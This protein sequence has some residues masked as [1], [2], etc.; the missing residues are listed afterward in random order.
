[1]K[2]Y[3]LSV[4]KWL[5]IRLSDFEIE[6]DIDD[7]RESLVSAIRKYPD[8]AENRLRQVSNN[9]RKDVV[10]KEKKVIVNDEIVKKNKITTTQ[11]FKLSK[12]RGYNENMEVNFSAKAPHFHL[13]ENGHEQVDKNG[14]VIGWVEGNHVVKRMCKSYEDHVMPF[15]VNKLLND[16]TKES[17]LN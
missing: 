3:N 10:E 9:F 11:G 4:L 5:V 8:M 7:L 2:C 16:I 15:E 12:T 14:Q 1:M 6:L 13:V 17:G